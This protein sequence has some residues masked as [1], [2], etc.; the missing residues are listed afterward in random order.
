MRQIQAKHGQL[1]AKGTFRSR[2]GER[3][4]NSKLFK[5]TFF[6]KSSVTYLSKTLKCQNDSKVEFLLGFLGQTKQETYTAFQIGKKSLGE[7]SVARG[8]VESTLAG[9]LADA[10]LVGLPLDFDRL[11]ITAQLVDQIEEKIRKPPIN[12]SVKALR[13]SILI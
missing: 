3:L 12:S 7:I 10:V 13:E 11:D 4:P 5:S 9:H 8:L 1:R 6:F 2:H